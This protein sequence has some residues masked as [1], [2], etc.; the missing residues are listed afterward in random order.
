[1][2]IKMVSDYTGLNFNEVIELDCYTFRVLTK[3]ALINKLSHTEEGMALLEED[4]LLKQTSPDM[5]KLRNMFGE[6]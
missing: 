6:K 1:M 2:L 4:W 3:D 5:G